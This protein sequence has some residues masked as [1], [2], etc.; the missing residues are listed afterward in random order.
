MTAINGIDVSVWQGD[1]AWD[2]V[3]ADGV[4][5]TMVLAGYGL[6]ADPNFARNIEGAA[7]QEIPCGVYLYSRAVTTAEAEEEAAFLLEQV[8]PYSIAYPA[9]MDMESPGQHALTKSQRTDLALAF[10]EKVEAAGLIPAVYSSLYWFETMLD[11]GQLAPYQRWV[12]DW[13]SKKPSIEGGVDLW[14][15]SSRGLVGGIS[16]YVDLDISYRDYVAGESGGKEPA[17]PEVPAAGTALLLYGVPLY[18]SATEKNRSATISGR[19]WI[20]DGIAVD[21]RLRI[22]NSAAR[23]GREPI[24]QNV[25]GYIDLADAKPEEA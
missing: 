12:T 13:S 14:Q 16:G 18:A 15:R 19:Y 4:G 23:V 1:I 10:C 21:G 7:A 9:S 20:Y 17:H 11:L 5:F 8:K 3:K 2:R 6:S 22:T 24:A 25:T